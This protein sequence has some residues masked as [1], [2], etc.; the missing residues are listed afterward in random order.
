MTTRN[1]PVRGQCYTLAQ[2][3]ELDLNDSPCLLVPTPSEPEFGVEPVQTSHLTTD[4]GKD[5]KN[6]VALNQLLFKYERTTEEWIPV[7]RCI[8]FFNVT[9]HHLKYEVRLETYESQSD[10]WW[11]APIDHPLEQYLGWDPKINGNLCPRSGPFGGDNSHPA[12]D[13]TLALLERFPEYAPK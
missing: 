9:R 13:S 1:Y 5:A 3:A 10:L 6:P 8:D 7:F 2:I 12:S 4:W 11:I